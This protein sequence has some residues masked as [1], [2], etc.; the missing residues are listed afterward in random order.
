MS[1]DNDLDP[2]EEIE[3]VEKIEQQEESDYEDEQ[4]EEQDDLKVYVQIS[5]DD[6][7]FGAVKKIL[8]ERTS[9]N[10]NLESEDGI[11]PVRNLEKESVDMEITI[12]KGAMIGEYQI[13]KNQGNTYSNNKTGDLVFI[14]IDEDEDSEDGEDDSDED[15]S[16]EDGADEDGSDEDG[17]DEDG[18][19]EDGADEDGSDEDGSDEDG[20]D[21]DGSDEDG[22]DED[23][24]NEDGSDE[25]G[26]DNES[27]YQSSDSS[28]PK[29]K[30]YD[31]VRGRNNNLEI[32]FPISLKEYYF[33]VERSIKYFGDKQLNIVYPFNI[34][35]HSSYVLSGYGINGAD[36][37]INFELELPDEIPKEYEKELSALLE[38][39][40]VSHNTVD[41]K[42][43]DPADIN[44]IDKCESESEDE[45]QNDD[46]NSQNVPSCAQQ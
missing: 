10:T 36:F 46:D 26:A 20:A 2:I 33:G 19:D 6:S 39:I 24:A 12:P 13:F 27:S 34:D 8:F 42:Q 5:L 29:K 17:S 21:E 4:D 23:G 35:T 30:K 37:I 25:D 22:S 45:E 43:L 9:F 15:G 38:K 41:F 40:C 44:I 1:K 18:S 28:S 14:Y 31:F 7:Y 3:E 11:E 32:T 16:D